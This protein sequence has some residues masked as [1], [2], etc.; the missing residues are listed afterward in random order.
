MRSTRFCLW[1][2]QPDAPELR[3]KVKFRYDRPSKNRCFVVIT[4]TEYELFPE[5]AVD[6]QV[7]VPV[8]GTDSNLNLVETVNLQ[9]SMVEQYDRLVRQSRERHGR[10][11][12]VTLKGANGRQVTCV[13]VDGRGNLVKVGGFNIMSRGENEWN[14]VQ[15]RHFKNR[16]GYAKFVF[17]LHTTVSTMLSKLPTTPTVLDGEPA[18]KLKFRGVTKI[19]T[20]RANRCSVTAGGR[21]WV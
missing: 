11:S 4:G 8:V 16:A 3:G 12:P 6:F 21:E 7:E 13:A 14:L 1:N 10:A 17:D 2:E 5:L 9:K 20:F 15:S 18:L 19:S